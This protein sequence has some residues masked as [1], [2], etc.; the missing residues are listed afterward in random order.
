MTCT[1][2]VELPVPP[3][4]AFALLTEPERLRRWKTVTAY[5]ELRAGGAYRFAVTPGRVAAGHYRE[6][7]PGRRLVFGW[8]WEGSPDLPPDASTVTVTIEPAGHG[9]SRVT[10]VHEGLS[11]E[12]EAGHAV[13]WD[14]YLGR[15]LILTESGAPTPD[16]W[17]RLADPLDA[18]SATECVLAAVQPLLR[19]VG[20]A[21]PAEPDARTDA[22]EL[23]EHL[24]GSMRGS[25]LTAGGGAA[26]APTGSAEQR[27]SEEVRRAVEAWR[28]RGLEGEVTG[29]SG[30]PL[31]A[32]TA[33]AYLP[34]ELTL[35]GWD[36]AQ[37]MGQPLVL[38]DEVVGYVRGL[39]EAVVPMLRTAGAVADEVPVAPEADPLDRLAAYAGRTP[40]QR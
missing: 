35:H 20:L 38:A 1:R 39:A 4:E 31:P 28:A 37:A 25:V 36:L 9:G 19:A 15:L 24:V 6:V 5:V 33:A 32:A 13:G 7:E 22:A 16:E 26:G 17:D 27:V 11:P 8:G 30:A 23:V 34:V 2:S 18:L 40:R 14:H 29:A 21:S 10:L 12:Q 3:D